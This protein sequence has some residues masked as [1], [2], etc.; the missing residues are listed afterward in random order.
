MEKY[1]KNKTALN[2]NYNAGLISI[3]LDQKHDA[4]IALATIEESGL[5]WRHFQIRRDSLEDV[6]VKLVGGFL[7]EHGELK[8]K[9]HD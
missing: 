2:V 5:P 1:L 7:G 8:M 9:E 3:S 4:Y 6:F